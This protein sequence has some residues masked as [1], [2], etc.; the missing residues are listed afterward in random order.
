MPLDV[1]DLCTKVL[2]KTDTVD[3]FAIDAPL[4]CASMPFLPCQILELSPSSPAPA[5]SHAQCSTHY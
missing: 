5:Q 4:S 1:D 3:D 2:E